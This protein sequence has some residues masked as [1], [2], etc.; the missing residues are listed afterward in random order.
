MLFYYFLIIIIHAGDVSGFVRSVCTFTN[1]ILHV[2][3]QTVGKYVLRIEL[4]YRE[5]V[6]L[7]FASSSKSESERGEVFCMKNTVQLNVCCKFA[8]NSYKSLS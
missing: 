7:S 3:R 5:H 2:T 4:I 1:P 8:N 6:S